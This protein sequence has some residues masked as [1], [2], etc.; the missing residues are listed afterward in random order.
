MRGDFRKIGILI[1][2]VCLVSC[3]RNRDHKHDANVEQLKIVR[4]EDELFGK[5]LY[6]FSES[7]YELLQKYPYFTALFANRIIEIG[8]TAKPNFGY[9]LK[10]FV[11]DQAIYDMYKRVAVLY[12]DF[13]PYLNELSLVLNNY[14]DAFAGKKLPVVYTYVS[15]LNQSIVTADGILGISLEKY[16]GVDEELYDK[17]YP[18]IPQYLRNTM[19]PEYIVPDA[20]RAWVTTDIAYLP[21][22]DN[23]IARVLHEARSVYITEQ[24][25]DEMPDTLL[26]GFTGKQMKFCK[27]NE[28]EMWKYLIEQKLLFETD[29]FIISHFV[30]PGPFTKDFTRDSPARAAVWIGY[31]II[32]SFMERQGKDFTLADLAAASDFQNIL[33][34]SKYNP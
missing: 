28:T 25:F 14:Q 17:V 23:F 33:N 16:L 13:T 32:D 5:E 30:N 24:L 26:W 27:E 34:E 9:S 8:D 4:Y 3:S 21:K 31:N 15:G 18:A 10:Q 20:V 12:K 1:L 2:V 11:S 22:Q 19:R 29:N 7:A 6:T